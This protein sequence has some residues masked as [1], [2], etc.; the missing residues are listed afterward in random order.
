MTFFSGAHFVEQLRAH[1]ERLLPVGTLR[2]RFYDWCRVRLRA[3]PREAAEQV[4]EQNHGAQSSGAEPVRFENGLPLPPDDLCMRVGGTKGDEFLSQGKFLQACLIRS[5][6][7]NFSWSGRRVFDFGCGVGRVLRHFAP[8]AVEAEFWA[9]DVHEPSIAWLAQ[10]MGG[11]FRVIMTD[12]QPKLPFP[13]NYFD[14]VYSLSVFTHVHKDWDR[15]FEEIRRILA[16]GGE[17]LCTFH[18]RVA[19]EWIMHQRFDE[20]SIGMKVHFKNRTWD[21]GG[22]QIF[23]SD[24]WVVENWGKILPVKAIVREGLVN[25]Q[26]IAVMQKA[27]SSG[28]ERVSFLQPFPY[29][30]ANTNF[31]GNLDYDPLVPRSWLQ[32]HGLLCDEEAEVRGWFSSAAGPVE[33]LRFSVDGYLIQ[34]QA[35]EKDLGVFE[36]TGRINLSFRAV[37]DMS[38]FA[39]G[40]HRGKVTA[41]DKM[42]SQH[43]IEFTTFKTRTRDQRAHPRA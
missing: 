42:G 43:S 10:N 12:T 18:S 15:W 5:L 33:D 24:W 19:Y 36:K 7:D 25:W 8:Q 13:S 3:V 26:S 2:R 22:P 20:R 4:P 30:P 35:L 29:S 32:E 21:L 23:H 31:S 9:C 38:A 1:K 28:K 41:T 17:F 16:P 40:A 34:P 6:P 39:E 11:I 37:L 27:A 14:L